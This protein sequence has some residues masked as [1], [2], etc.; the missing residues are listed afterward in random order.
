M[1]RELNCILYFTP[2]AN[3]ANWHVLCNTYMKYKF[4]IQYVELTNATLFLEKYS[5]VV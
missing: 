2:D 3:R 5:N 4:S 1:E